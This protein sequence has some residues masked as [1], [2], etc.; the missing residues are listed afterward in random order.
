MVIMED[1]V[2][3]DQV[4]DLQEKSMQREIKKVIQDIRGN[5][6]IILHIQCDL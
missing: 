5:G 4:K 1:L 6:V 2:F 3:E